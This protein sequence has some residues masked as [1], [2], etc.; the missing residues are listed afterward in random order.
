LAAELSA[1]IKGLK[2][3][4]RTNHLSSFAEDLDRNEQLTKLREASLQNR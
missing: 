4:E 3:E 2:G 1:D